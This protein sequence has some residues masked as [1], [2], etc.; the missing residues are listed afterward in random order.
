MVRYLRLFILPV[1]L[2]GCGPTS[3]SRN[4]AGAPTVGKQNS[5]E[6]QTITDRVRNNTIQAKANEIDDSMVKRVTVSYGVRELGSS[7]DSSKIGQILL[8]LRTSNRLPSIPIEPGST[9]D[10]MGS[11]N[12]LL[13]SGSRVSFSFH[14]DDLEDR[15]SPAVARAV[16][17]IVPNLRDRWN[18]EETR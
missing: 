17:R 7:D 9:T 18:R 8:A 6:Q 5:M 3:G 11:I 2:A 14:A 12:F 1:V 16:E 4:S 15:W 13:V 10:E